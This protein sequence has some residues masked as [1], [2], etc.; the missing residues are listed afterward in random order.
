[1]PPERKSKP[2]S[3][4]HAALAQAVE[5]VIA[6]NDGMTQDSVAFGAGMTAKQVNAICRGQ[7]NP[8]Y[9]NLLKLCTGLQVR[10]G[11]LMTR[12]DHMRDEPSS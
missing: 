10:L 7:S 4:D 1:M 8:T 9:L 11:D 5:S 3:P 12:A 6:E 2:L